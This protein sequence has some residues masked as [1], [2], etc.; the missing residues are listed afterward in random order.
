MNLIFASLK[1]EFPFV[2]GFFQCADY[3]CVNPKGIYLDLDATVFIGRIVLLPL[4]NLY[5][6]LLTLFTFRPSSSLM[7]MSWQSAIKKFVLHTEV[8]QSSVYNQC[9]LP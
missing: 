1:S 5:L 6:F 2:F 3:L 4:M 7:L 8:E 9:G